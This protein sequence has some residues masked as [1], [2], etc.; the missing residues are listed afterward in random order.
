M[1]QKFL[2]EDLSIYENIYILDLTLSKENYDKIE[3][4]K[5]KDKFK[6]FDHHQTHVFASNKDY[7]TIDTKECASSLFYQYLKNIYDF[8]TLCIKTYIQLVKSLDLYTFEEDGN[9]DAPYLSDLLTLYGVDIYISKITKR[10]KEDTFVF[11]DFEKEWFLLDKRNREEYLQK[12]S[13]KMFFIKVDTYIGGIVFAEKY[14][15]ELAHFLLQKYENLDFAA[16]INPQ[17]GVSLRGNG[18]IDLST[19]A[20]KYDPKGGGH[21]NAAGF[22]FPKSLQ[23]KVI[24]EL[25]FDCVIKDESN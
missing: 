25:F 21:K 15:N 2:E 22:S 5:Y 18:K 13:E 14:R 8:D 6:V 10:L 9:M 1:K 23:E 19:F 16:C 4:S 11:D 24:Q 12:K 3:S 17:G 20:K 7:V